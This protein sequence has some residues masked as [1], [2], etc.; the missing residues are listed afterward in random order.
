MGAGRGDRLTEALYRASNAEVIL[1]YKRSIAV[2]IG[3][4]S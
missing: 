2:I 3:C 4:S 1:S